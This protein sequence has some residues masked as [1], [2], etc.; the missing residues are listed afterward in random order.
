MSCLS[1][2]VAI[3]T[4]VGL[5]VE[6]LPLWMDAWGNS[7]VVSFPILLLITPYV[8]RLTKKLIT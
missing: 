2:F 8:R 6:F 3:Y 4:A 5:S 1:T 7:W